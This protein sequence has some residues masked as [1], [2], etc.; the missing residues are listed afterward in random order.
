MSPTGTVPPPPHTTQCICTTTLSQNLAARARAKTQAS[1]IWY[2]VRDDAGASSSGCENRRN[3][4]SSDAVFRATGPL[5]PASCRAQNAL[6][7]P[8]PGLAPTPSSPAEGTAS[9]PL[10][11]VTPPV[12]PSLAN[13]PGSPGNA[14]AAALAQSRGR[15]QA[16][17]PPG[18]ARTPC[19]RTSARGVRCP[20]VSLRTAASEKALARSGVNPSPPGPEPP[21]ARRARPCSVSVRKNT[22]GSIVEHVAM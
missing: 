7:P 8:A 3:D 11:S 17:R 16:A 4:R 20:C 6:T 9:L 19:R 22:T 1:G 13:T 5:L 12:P 10:R 2:Q 18:N 21:A 14:Q 15:R